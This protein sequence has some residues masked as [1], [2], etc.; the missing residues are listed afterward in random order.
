MSLT[1]IGAA[2]IAA[3]RIALVG[4][5]LISEAHVRGYADH[6]GRAKVVTCFD[7]DEA[8]A[9]ERAAQAGGADIAPSFESIL[10]DPS[11]DAIDL[12]TP[13]HLHPEAVIAAAKAGK[14]VCC[15]KPL[16]RT[17]AECEKMAEAHAQAGT[18]LYYAEFYRTMPAAVMARKLIEEGRIGALVGIQATYAHWQGG[19]YLGTPW[20]YDPKVAGGGVLLDGGIH[21]V[22]LLRV[23]GGDVD[24]VSCFTRRVRPELGGE[25]TS[26]VNIRF[27]G[28]HFGTMISTQAAGT[29]YSGPQCAI[30]GTEGILTI[31]GPFGP[32]A[33]HRDDLPD[34]I[35]VLQNDRPDLFSAMLAHF[36]DA[37]DGQP[38]ISPAREGIE[39]LRVVLAAYR[40]AELGREVH[41][42]E[43]Q[44]Q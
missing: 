27:A 7:I 2:P 4:C 28:G 44:A 35:E 14:H 21:T 6:S 16:A 24:S 23:V 26:V 29:W 42:A 13:P 40:S 18:V 34:R 31:G 33:L 41:V 32:L 20:R 36:L 37:V 22:D 12:C 17:L 11:I 39:D 10:E 1:P 25:D 19:A 5:G 8:K 30:F 38:N 9:K 43:I 15:Q 3:T